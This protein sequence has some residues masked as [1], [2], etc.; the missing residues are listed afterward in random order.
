MLFFDTNKRG[1]GYEIVELWINDDIR[2]SA[3]FGDV[4]EK[5]S[6]LRETAEKLIVA[7]QNLVAYLEDIED[8]AAVQRE[9][10]SIAIDLKE[11]VSAVEL[12]LENPGEAFAYSARRL[13]G[14]R[15]R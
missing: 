4:A 1:K 10:A 15:W 13:A 3:T 8:A 7:C 11:Q 5:G 12:I 6:A 2:K 9:I 14:Q